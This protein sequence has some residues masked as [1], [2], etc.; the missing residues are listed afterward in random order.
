MIIAKPPF[1]AQ[2]KNSARSAHPPPYIV[3]DAPICCHHSRTIVL[4][5]FASCTTKIFVHSAR[6]GR[7]AVVDPHCVASTS[8]RCSAHGCAF[9]AWG[10]APK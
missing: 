4:V 9:R 1:F 8:G 3:V 2:H 6:G 7:G 5:P 10:Y